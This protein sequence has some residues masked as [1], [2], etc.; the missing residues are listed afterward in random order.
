MS[1]YRVLAESDSIAEFSLGERVRVFDGGDIR[2]WF[3]CLEHNSKSPED[4][5]L[6]VT[7]KQEHVGNMSGIHPKLFHFKQCRKLEPA[8]PRQLK[9]CWTHNTYD[10]PPEVHDT[11]DECDWIVMEEVMD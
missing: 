5:L 8:E 3:V 7:D 4:G 11:G 9:Y 1:R 6:G 10:G 2:D